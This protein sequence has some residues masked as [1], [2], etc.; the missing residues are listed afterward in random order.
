MTNRR[1]A[2]GLWLITGAVAVGVWLWGLAH[3]PLVFRQEVRS[4]V[5]YTQPIG[6]IAGTQTASQSFVAP[7][8]G[9]YR[10]EVLLHNNGRAN[11]GTLTLRLKESPNGPDLATSAVAA[12]GIGEESWAALD[13][14][15]RADSSGRNYYFQL[16]AAD[17][18]PGEGVTAPVR[19]TAKYPEGA[20]YRNGQPVDGDLVFRAYFSVDVFT[21]TA[22][23]LTQL[24]EDRP[25]LWGSPL[26]YLAVG[27]GYVVLLVTLAR[28][29][30][31]TLHD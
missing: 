15:P 12:E 7:H 20:A 3:T 16:D 21:R 1:L 9:L 2:V 10:V 4:V 8:S 22:V 5:V 27:F 30:F 24:T 23:L 11:R 19:P 6:E 14:A 18:L 29:A 26:L 17:T 13:F 28:L 31:R 25:G